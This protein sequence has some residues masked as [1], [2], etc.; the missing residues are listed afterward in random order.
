[1]ACWDEPH[2]RS[3]VVAGTCWGRPAATQALRVT[4]VLC[5]PA[6]VTQPPMTSS[7]SS[8]STPVRS[9]SEVRAK[10][11]QVDRV[12]GGE[13]TSPLA[14]RRPHH[15]D[16]DC[17]APLVAHVLSSLSGVVSLAAMRVWLTVGALPRPPGPCR[18]HRWP[19]APP[20][21]Q[22]PLDADEGAVGRTVVGHRAVLEDDRRPGDVQDPVHLLF[23]DE[24]GGPGAV[25]LAQALVDGVDHHRSEAEG[26]LVGDQEAGRGDQ[27]LGQREDALLAA[28]ERAPVLLAATAQDR[29]RLV[30]PVQ[31][32]GHLL[33]PELLAEQHPQ[34]LLDGQVGEDPSALGHVGAPGPGDLVGRLSGDVGAAEA[35][36]SAE[37]GQQS[38][39]HPGHRGLAGAVGADQRGHPSGR[40]REGHIEQRPVGAVGGAHVVDLERRGV[41]RPARC[42]RSAPGRPGGPPDRP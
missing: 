23:D 28:G 39:H 3:T 38:G 21:G 40:H 8:G 16:D 7:T 26:D 12:P 33:P 22:H 14:Q 9:T 6:W 41:A 18:P 36:R 30:G 13:R 29:E 37:A 32:V 17:V 1:M 19:P 25:D 20:G 24:Q 34:V 2:W 5:S 42:T 27:D 4:L 11:E 31:R 10:P 15:V 35:D